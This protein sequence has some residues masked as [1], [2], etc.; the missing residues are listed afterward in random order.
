VRCVAGKAVLAVTVTNPRSDA[1]T[2][3]VTT[4]YGAK[5]SVKVAAGASKALSF[6]TRLAAVPAGIVTVTNAADAAFAAK[7]CG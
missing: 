2:V 1:A 3:D 5:S 7:T 6:S 4:P